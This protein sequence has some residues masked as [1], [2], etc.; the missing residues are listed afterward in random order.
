MMKIRVLRNEVREVDGLQVAGL[1]D[2]WG[3]NFSRSQV[4]RSVDWSEAALTLCHNPDGVDLP[5][6]GRCG[7]DFVGAHAWRSVQAPFLPPAI[8]PVKNQRYTSGAFDV[9]MGGC[10]IST[11][12]SG[13]CDGYGLL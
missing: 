6:R 8:L 1:D 10:C 3:P 13:I 4:L 2:L 5:E 11:G 9:G 7:V 12:G